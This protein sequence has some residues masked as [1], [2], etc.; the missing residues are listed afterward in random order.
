M[1]SFN[2]VTQFKPA[3]DQPQAIAAIVEAFHAGARQVCLWGAT[4]TGKTATMAWVIEQLGKPTLVIA[5]NKTLAGQLCSELRQFFPD[6]AVEYFVSYYDYYQP[7]AYIAKSDLYI[8][9]DAQV[10]EEIDKLRHSATSALFERR[11]VVIVASVSCI[12]GLG[13]PADYRDLTVR[14]RVGATQEREQVLRHLV[15]IRYSRNDINFTRGTFRVRGDVLEVFPAGLGEQAIRVEFFGDEVDRITE[16]DVLTG[17]VLG[18]RDH[19][20]IYPNSHYVT[21]KEKLRGAVLSIEDELNERLAELRAADKLLEAQRLEQR[22]RHDLEMLRTF[23]YCTGIENYSR[24]M[25]D[26][27]P[28]EPPYTLLDYFPRDMLIIIDESHQTVPQLG[29]MYHGEMSRKDSLIDHGFRLPSARDNRPL[30]FSEFETF[31]DKVLYVSA[32]PGPYELRHADPVVEQVVRPTGLLDPQVTVR[33]V[34]GQ[35]DDLLAAVGERTRQGQRVLVTVLTKKMAEE[36][37]DFLREQGVK[38]RYL[39]SEIDTLERMEIIRD[40]RLGVFD[41]LVGIN[42]LREGLDLPEVS[43]VAILDADKE[44]FLRSDTALIQTM[45]RAARHI[46]GT[47][48]MYADRIT[49]SMAR[50]MQATERR[51]QVQA[52]FNRRHGITPRSVHKEVR[53][54][55]EATRVAERGPAYLAD[56]DLRSVPRAQVPALVERLRKEMKTASHNLEFEH[57]ALLRD[58]IIE[59][60][61]RRAGRTVSRAELRANS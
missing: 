14:L 1:S 30:Q 17:H 39:H 15:D 55:I 9:K 24:H 4:G 13:S 27:A 51:R 44:G 43:L 20:T 56:K 16:V 46:D 11:D 53:D 26:R 45:G 50:A 48:I 25:T 8:E 29:A 41:V 59:L 19:V 47:V 37:T 40:L 2:T 22:T 18:E 57:A 49:G 60:E 34:A 38:V 7:E 31:M 5:H 58:M 54:V 52:E 23:G 12:Y 36:L 33:P 21:D 61:G 32:T 42:L 3:G 6:N 10:N 28:G 35:V